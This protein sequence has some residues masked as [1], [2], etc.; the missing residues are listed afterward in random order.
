MPKLKPS[1]ISREDE[2][3][4]KKG[5]GENIKTSPKNA[6]KIQWLEETLSD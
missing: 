3:E 2:R 5:L 6:R 1:D 4:R